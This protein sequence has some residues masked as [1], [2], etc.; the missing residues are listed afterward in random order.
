MKSTP[1]NFI[2]FFD[3]SSFDWLHF[4][5][6]D[7]ASNKV[8][9]KKVR[10]HHFESEKTLPALLNFLKKNKIFLAKPNQSRSIAKI[11]FV[12][13]PGSFSGI[14]VG[15]AIA[16]A[17]GF[18]KNIPVFAL[19][20]NQVPKNLANLISSKAKKI[21]ANPELDYGS[22]PKITREKKKNLRNT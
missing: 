8:A 12:S 20:K 22:S 11:Y 6:V 21:S 19:K 1:Q 17:F 16:L 15:A 14:R 13:G 5:L 9:Q 3:S 2:L 10:M 4:S 18:A 7:L